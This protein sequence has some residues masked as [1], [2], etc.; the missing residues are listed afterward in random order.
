[1]NSLEDTLVENAEHDCKELI[2]EIKSQGNES[3]SISYY[4]KKGYP[5][6][7]EVT[8]FAKENN[9]SLIVLGTK[10]ASGLQKI[11]MGS[12]AAA[13]INKSEIPV[14][15]VPEFAHV[16]S[17]KHIVYATDLANMSDE[18]KVL[19]PLAELFDATLNIIHV[20]SPS[21]QT[22]MDAKQITQDIIKEMNYDKITFRVSVDDDILAALEAYM[23]FI[24]ADMLAMFTHNTTFIDRLFADSVTRQ[25]A[26]QTSVPLLTLKK[27][28]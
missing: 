19:V 23:A 14:I 28:Y 12:N 27:V 16:S 21:S 20:V 3:L 24:K 22:K 9:V 5:L 4:V 17:M 11:F 18:M 15:T 26:F 6:E 7:A 13:V 10:G 8:D 1:M 25:M 2:N